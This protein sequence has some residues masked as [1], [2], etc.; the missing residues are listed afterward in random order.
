MRICKGWEVSVSSSSVL[1]VALVG[2]N[3]NL[4]I[5]SGPRSI[6][7]LLSRLCCSNFKKAG[8]VYLVLFLWNLTYSE[9]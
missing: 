1:K 5:F 9:W 8:K 4:Q 7:V 2:F 6:D 3:N